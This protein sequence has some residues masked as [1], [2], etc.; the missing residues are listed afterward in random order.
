MIQRTLYHLASMIYLAIPIALLQKHKIQTTL[1]CAGL[2]KLS[3]FSGF[4][5]K[6][7]FDKVQWNKVE[8]QIYGVPVYEKLWRGR[9]SYKGY[10]HPRGE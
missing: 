2:A 7:S 6:G 5:T 4:A 1:S 8:E 9:M 10:L 3:I